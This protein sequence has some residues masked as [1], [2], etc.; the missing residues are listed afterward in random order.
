MYLCMNKDNIMYCRTIQKKKKQN[1][2][3]IAFQVFR[4]FSDFLDV[5]VHGFGPQRQLSLLLLTQT[6]STTTTS[7]T[8][9]S[10]IVVV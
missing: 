8:T 9:I 2:T 1:K 5:Y 4:R 7:R 6:I 10:R 3:Y